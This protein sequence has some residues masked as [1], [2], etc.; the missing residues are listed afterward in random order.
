MK[1]LTVYILGTTL[2]DCETAVTPS[3]TDVAEGP[4]SGKEYCSIE[5]IYT[6]DFRLKIFRVKLLHVKNFVGTA[7]LGR[8]HTT[9]KAIVNVI[10]VAYI[11]WIP[12]NVG[13]TVQR[14]LPTLSGCPDYPNM[15][16]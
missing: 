14:V 5:T 16:F 3:V 6:V 15:K 2:K 4:Q 9:P 11:Q 10:K 7:Y 13:T 1:L 8:T 12:L